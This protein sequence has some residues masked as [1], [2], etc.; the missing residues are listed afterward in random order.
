MARRV[1]HDFIALVERV[2]ERNG[3][4]RPAGVSTFGRELGWRGQR[5]ATADGHLAGEFLAPNL[6]ASPGTDRKGPTSV[7]KSHCAMDLV[8][9]PNGTALDLKLLPQSTKGESGINALIALMRSF[10]RLGGFFMHIDVV[11]N[12]VLRDAQAHPENYPNLP[13]RVSGWSARFTTLSKDWQDMI[14]NRTE[15][16]C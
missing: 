16:G 13:V 5:M 1:F 9:L 10:V 7:V 2:H 14:I 8:R 11:S 15:Q 6:S 12:E 3:V 4:L